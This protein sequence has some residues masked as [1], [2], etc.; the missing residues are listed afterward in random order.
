M[1]SSKKKSQKKPAVSVPEITKS[2]PSIGGLQSKGFSFFQEFKEFAFQGNVIDLAVGIIIGA[3]FNG[4]VQSLVKDIILPIFGWILGNTDF[5][6][7]YITLGK[8]SYENL[9]VA[10]EA[11]APIILYGVFINEIINFLIV[12]FSIF[13]VLRVFLKQKKLSSATKKK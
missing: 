13:F 4:L 9:T 11:G 6:N 2:I 5:S 8:T 3:A 1:S 12:S 7:L 10:Q